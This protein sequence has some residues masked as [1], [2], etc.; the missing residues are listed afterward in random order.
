MPQSKRIVIKIGSSLL[1]NPEL[2]TP[3]WAFI[4]QLLSD[5]KTLR[6]DG[7]EV[8]V[9]SSGAVAL[10]LSTI[11]ESPETAACATSRQRRHAACPSC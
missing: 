7:Y 1:A 2:L 5:V 4:Q 11:G 9:C 6:D 3:R 10:G 8:I